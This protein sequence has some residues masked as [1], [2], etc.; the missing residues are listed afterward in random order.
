M[1]PHQPPSCSVCKNFR[2]ARHTTTSKPRENTEEILFSRAYKRRPLSHFAKSCGLGC[3]GCSLVVDA[4]EAWQP[5]WTTEHVDD[6]VVDVKLQ[7]SVLALFLYLLPNKREMV[8]S[9]GIF[10]SQ[11]S[12]TAPLSNRPFCS[13]RGIVADTTSRAASER[14]T[15]WLT[16]CLAN[17]PDCGGG[18][19]EYMPRRVLRVRAAGSKNE[20][21]QAI[22]L[23]ED[24]SKTA[25]YAALSYCWG[26]DLGGVVTTLLANKKD[27]ITQGIPVGSLPKTIQDAITVCRGLG[28]LYLWVDALCIVQDDRQ[29]WAREAAQMKNVYRCAQVTITAHAAASCKDGFLGPQAYGQPGWQRSFWTRFGPSEERNRAFIRMG[30][31]VYAN[32]GDDDPEPSSSVLNTRGWT[33][34][35]ALLPR[36]TL[37]FVG[38]EMVWECETRHFC[39]CGHVEG[40]GPYND[41]PMIKTAFWKGDDRHDEDDDWYQGLDGASDSDDDRPPATTAT[42][43]T[44]GRRNPEGNGW[45][46]LVE[47]YSRR[48][49]TYG[50]DKL[51]AIAGLA[52]MAA[53]ENRPTGM[54][55]SMDDV[56]FAGIFRSDIPAQLLWF[57]KDDPDGVEEGK[58]QPP[59][60]RH[61]DPSHYRAPSWSWASVDGRISYP[62]EVRLTRD[63]SKFAQGQRVFPLIIYSSRTFSIPGLDGGALA[64]DL[65]MEGLIAPVVLTVAQLPRRSRYTHEIRTPGHRFKGRASVVRPR[66]G[67]MYEV[68]CDEIQDFDVAIGGSICNC[69][70][71]I[72]DSDGAGKDDNAGLDAKAAVGNGS[73]G[74]KHGDEGDAKSVDSNGLVWDSDA[75]TYDETDG[76]E[77]YGSDG[78][79]L[80]PDTVLSESDS[81]SDNQSDGEGVREHDA[82]DGEIEN[83]GRPGPPVIEEG[84]SEEGKWCEKCAVGS[85][86]WDRPGFYCLRIAV[87]SD[88]FF[89]VLQ[90]SRL[91]PQA[92]E[93]IGIGKIALAGER[94]EMQSLFRGGETRVIRLV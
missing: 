94:D 17:H 26:S 82:S 83:F 34:Q 36:R 64:R 86:Y 40:I 22:Y 14:A 69:L 33:L 78:R 75:G 88:L 1:A 76:S 53:T 49:L 50:S 12:A 16:D 46:V 71:V 55:F 4:I 61:P 52:E 3:R 31:P 91:V 92:W 2:P 9:L 56:Y 51:P 11:E 63:H 44:T 25:P 60:R 35:E 29:D 87:S 90:R 24:P 70:H 32:D 15:S 41:D 42:T 59:K 23:V 58:I 47:R 30:E 84:D 81:G 19:E 10:Q 7:D 62:L 73:E 28:H 48:N 6:A 27:H 8:Q 80:S 85:G 79:S 65:T 5:G 66:D 74:N 93:R 21:P 57:V 18:D 20:S 67:K 43:T 38:E 39:E 13:T 68:V 54:S 89:L 45:M 77:D 72:H 37:H